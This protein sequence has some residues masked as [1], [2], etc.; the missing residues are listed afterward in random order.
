MTGTEINTLH[1]MF[2]KSQ[3]WL[4]EERKINPETILK[5]QSRLLSP[6]APLSWAL[7]LGPVVFYDSES[8]ET[9]LN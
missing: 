7:G 3:E 6:R 9:T 5:D 4:V 2:T 1:S 8:N